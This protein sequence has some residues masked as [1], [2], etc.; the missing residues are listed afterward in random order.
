[1]LRV[2]ITTPR[3][4]CTDATALHVYLSNGEHFLTSLEFAVSQVWTSR[5]GILLEKTASTAKLP[6][7]T[8]VPM[9]RLFSLSHP[10]E[11]MCPVLVRPLIGTMGYMLDT[12]Y[13]VVYTDARTDLVLMYDNKMKK[14]FVS[15]LRRATEEEANAI[16][17]LVCLPTLS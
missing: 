4:K 3:H 10:L 16:C 7:A 8:T 11:E 1:M 12:D 14:H 6:N 9:P 13:R 15:R 2:V 17:E 5:F